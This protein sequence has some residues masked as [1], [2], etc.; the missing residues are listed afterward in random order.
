MP[1]NYIFFDVANTLLHKPQLFT[2]INQVFVEHGYEIEI[3]HL[4]R[5]HKLLSEAIIFPDKTSKEFYQNFNAELL[6]AIGILPNPKL[7]E[8]IF[9]V[10]TYMEWQPFEDTDFIEKITIPTG[11]I[12][13]WDT[14]LESKLKSYFNCDFF[15]IYGSQKEGIKKPSLD[16]YKRAIENL[17]CSPSQILYVGDSI[18]LDTEPARKLGIEAILIDREN[19]FPYYKE[20]KI[21]SL[22]QLSMF[23]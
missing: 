21:N 7:L 15:E 18:K 6:Y 8:D 20:P 4:K 9:S 22:H 10:C 14:S 12:S 5:V 16:F 2:K 19:V 11:I 1:Y 23:L 13:N 3:Q 17:D